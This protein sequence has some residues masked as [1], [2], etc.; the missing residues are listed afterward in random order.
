MRAIVVGAGKI[1]YNLAK[2]LA[3]EKH[4]VVVIE[5]SEERAKVIDEYLDVKVLVGN[6]ASGLILEEAGTDK[7]G[8]LI[9]VTASD[10]V[11]MIACMVAKAYGVGRTVARVRNPEYID[12][13]KK[14]HK[15]FP[16]IDL[17]INPELV[18]AKEIV[19]LIDASEALDVEYYAEGKIQLLEL[20]IKENDPVVNKYLRELKFDYSFLIIAILRNGELIIPS[21]CDQILANDIIFLLAKTAEMIHL[22]K[23]FGIERVK[24]QRIMVLGGGYTGYYLAKLLEGRNHSVKIIEK[25]YNKCLDIAQSLKNALVLFGDATD[26]DFLSNEGVGN[27]DVFVSLSDD[28]KLN[29]LVSLIVKQ[30]GVKRTIAQ[31]GHSDYINLIENVGVDVGISPRVFTANEI[32][33]YVHKDDNILSVT[34][35]SNESA[36]MTELIIAENS[37]VAHKKLRDLEL[38]VGSLIGSIYRDNEVIIPHGDDE[39]KPRDVVTLFTLPKAT[40]ALNYLA[41]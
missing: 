13:K 35:L 1:G 18:T 41:K 16:G 22:E 3:N 33:R 36:E 15:A 11:N 40:H 2:I 39:L 5:Q 17:M 21:G 20:R 34:L 37:M 25:E 27:A 38:P 4:D 30:L 7:A 10:E 14:M 8:L 6:G 19:K 31:V 26:I 29:I 9:A 32:L 24:A 23:A 28:D 12:Q